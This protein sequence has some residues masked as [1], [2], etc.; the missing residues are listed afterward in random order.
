MDNLLSPEPHT[1]NCP[2]ILPL[3]YNILFSPCSSEP[4]LTITDVSSPSSK[5]P[6]SPKLRNIAMLGIRIWQS[7]RITLLSEKVKVSH[8]EKKHSCMLRMLTY[9]ATTNPQKKIMPASLLHLKSAK[10]TVYEYS[11]KKRQQLCRKKTNKTYSGWDTP[12]ST[13]PNEDA[14]KYLIKGGTPKH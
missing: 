2:S 9:K 7:S 12:E 13:E 11:A 14:S 8:L 1:E 4:P 5:Q 10:A 6:W 3:I